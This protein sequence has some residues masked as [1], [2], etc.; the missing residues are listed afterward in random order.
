MRANSSPS[1][2]HAVVQQTHQWENME[3]ERSDPLN[4]TPGV[5]PLQYGTSRF[6][7]TRHSPRGCHLSAEGL[8]LKPCGPPRCTSRCPWCPHGTHRSTDLCPPVSLSLLLPRQPSPNVTQGQVREAGSVPG[9]RA[10]HRTPR[11]AGG[12]QWPATGGGRAGGT[13]EGQGTQEDQNVFVRSGFSF[14]FLFQEASTLQK[15]PTK[16]LHFYTEKYAFGL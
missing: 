11:V 6:G 15:K 16:T 9:C 12:A 13:H 2:L 7:K 3:R 10:N 5:F 4:S 8:T 1:S 14:F